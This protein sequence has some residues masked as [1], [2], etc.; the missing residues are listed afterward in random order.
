MKTITRK[1]TLLALSLLLTSFVFSQV[2]IAN[3]SDPVEPNSV[4]EL[5]SSD[6][7]LLLPRLALTST[8]S[9]SPLAAHVAGML[10]YNTATTGD[11]TP[12]LYYNTGSAW[13]NIL[14]PVVIPA[15][16]IITKMSTNAPSGYLYCD[17]SAVSR[18][19][20][21]A[22]FADIGVTYGV[23]DGSTT[24]NLPDLR[25]LFLRGQ[26]DGQPTDPD[27]ESR[28][29]S[30][31]GTTIGDNVGTKQG[32]ATSGP[33]NPFIGTTSTGGSHGHGLT[34]WDGATVFATA[35]TRFFNAGNTWTSSG[36]GGTNTGAVASGGSH[37]HTTTVTAGGDLETRPTNIYVRYYIKY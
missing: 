28:T 25:G 11:V 10:V 23:G 4:L 3:N 16:T 5:E 32:D 7:G 13:V 26:A 36:S 27:R 20:Y 9:A 29:D 24:F 37:D 35:T 34:Y 1:Y 15:G 12:G 8:S 14:N 21:A 31:D 22:L 2:K 19:T 33:N 30:G 6:K 17:G 18:T